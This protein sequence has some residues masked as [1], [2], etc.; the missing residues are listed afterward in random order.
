MVRVLDCHFSS[1][2]DSQAFKEHRFT[3]ATAANDAVQMRRESNCLVGQK[4]CAL[5]TDAVN[6]GMDNLRR[7]KIKTNAG[8]RIKKGLAEGFNGW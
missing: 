3:A 4:F 2:A 7:L 1:Q 5:D 8:F 6:P